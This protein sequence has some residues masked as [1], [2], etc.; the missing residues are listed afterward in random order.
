M[1]LHLRPAPLLLRRAASAALSSGPALP[2]AVRIEAGVVSATAPLPPI[3]PGRGFAEVLLTHAERHAR[4]D[5]RRV[6]ILDAGAEAPSPPL[7]YGDLSHRV[8]AAARGLRALGVSRGGVVALHL[9]NSPEF[10]VAFIAASALGATVTTSN[11]AYTVPELTHQLRD[12]GAAVLVT[13][14]ALAAVAGAAAAAAG[15]P[16]RAQLV[17][18]APAARFLSEGDG[19]RRGP[20]IEDVGDLKTALL[21]LPYSSGTTGLPKG[22]RLSHANILANI[23]QCGCHLGLRPTDSIMGVL[24]F[25]RKCLRRDQRPSN[26]PIHT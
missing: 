19:A 4:A 3:G 6:A 9:P 8:G 15:L 1:F 18:G 16:A 17:L 21:V 24:P 12:S 10:A 7:T 20:E 14:P 22:V 26:T 11:P 25:Y 23:E 2:A 5:A 13:T